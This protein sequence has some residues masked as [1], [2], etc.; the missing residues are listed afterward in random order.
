MQVASLLDRGLLPDWSI[1]IGIRRL[2][3]RRLA[4]LD[5]QG[6]ESAAHRH[7]EWVRELRT[8][9]VAIAV[10]AANRQHYEV[11]SAFYELVLGRNLKYSC[12]LWSGGID[13]LDRA[14]AAM[15][16]LT[17][18]RAEIEDGMQ[19]LELGC[20]WGSLTLWLAERF[21]RCEILAVSNSASQRD[22]IGARARD[23][24]LRN[25]EVVTADMRSFDTD[26]RF[27][28]V[29]SVE[30]FEHMRNY[31]VLLQRISR[32]LDRDGKLFV[33][34]FTHGRHAYPF[35]VDGDDDWMGRYFF[36][37]GQMP[38]DRLL[39]Y[40][41]EDLTIDDHWQIDGRHYARTAA[42]WLRNLDEHRGRV[43]A[44]FDATYGADAARML[45]YWRVFFMACAELWG[46][47]GGHEWFVSHYRF[48]NRS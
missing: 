3:R 34:V 10:D 43:R 46:F 21:P 38:S 40:F 33:H 5:G 20:G 26:R 32:W 47:R 8:S 45:V 19:V 6:L 25:V 44:L 27:D 42:A 36:T 1:R 48:R 28:R 7:M 29:V 4:L 41:Q 11:P 13:S 17:T 23:R 9:P 16:A 12:A 18:E 39:L 35:E 14:E 2:L 15:L 37:G 24:G 31:R 22:L 30:M